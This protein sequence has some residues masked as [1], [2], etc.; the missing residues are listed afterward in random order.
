IDKKQYGIILANVEDSMHV[1]SKFID[2]LNLHKIDWHDRNIKFWITHILDTS[3]NI[4][5]HFEEEKIKNP[6]LI[7]SVENI[8]EYV[9]EM[10]KKL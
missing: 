4:I 5:L 8:R 9:S 10:R 3:D 1:L 7:V 6:R 2:F